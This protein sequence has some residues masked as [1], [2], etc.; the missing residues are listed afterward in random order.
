MVR[1]ASV[2]PLIF[3]FHTLPQVH[4]ILLT[5]SRSCMNFLVKKDLTLHKSKALDK[6]LTS[7][8]V[9]RNKVKPHLKPLL[10]PMSNASIDI[11]EKITKSFVRN[12]DRLYLHF[13]ILRQFHKITTLS[14]IFGAL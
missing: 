3:V 11:R 4:S 14:F 12:G 9:Q 5:N 6:F 7:E 8:Y 1:L 13:H 2:S 10:P